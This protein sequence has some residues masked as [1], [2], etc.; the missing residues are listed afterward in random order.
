[1]L[2][3]LLAFMLNFF[4]FE[5]DAIFENG[6]TNRSTTL[7][8]FLK[9]ETF[10][11]FA[12]VEAIGTG[13][14]RTGKAKDMEFLVLFDKIHGQILMPFVNFD[15]RE[16]F[17][18]TLTNVLREKSPQARWTRVRWEDLTKK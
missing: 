6:L 10:Q 8:Q 5:I 7:A 14:M 3:G 16:V 12:G 2:T 1:M 4:G 15:T 17:Y 11:T 18:K 9:G 13:T